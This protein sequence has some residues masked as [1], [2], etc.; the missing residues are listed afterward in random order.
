MKKNI[1]FITI[2]QAGGNIGLLFQELG[3]KVLFM[4]TS[5]EDL[6][7]LKGAKQ[8]YHI[9]NGE[10]CNK[11]RDKAKSLIFEDFSAISK[12]ILQNFKEEEFIYVIFSSGGGTGSGSSPMLIELLIQHLDKKVGAIT[13]LPN[14]N[15]PSKPFINAY[16]CFTELEGIENV[17][18]TFILDNNSNHDKL[19]INI[20]FVD[21]F[22][23]FINISGH[24]D[25]SGNI[26]TAEMKELLSTR[27][28]AIISKIAKSTSSTSSLLESVNKNIFAPLEGDKVIKY[29]G[30]STSAQIDTGDVMQE[31]GT[32][33]DVYQATNPDDT[34]AIFCGLSFPYAVLEQFRESIESSREAIT[35]S[36]TTTAEIKL[37]GGVN[38]LTNVRSNGVTPPKE[39]TEINDVFAKFMKK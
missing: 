32:C 35:K 31:V 20:E 38:F 15:E 28:A 2:G 3:Y 16:E 25:T 21:L 4:N 1:G 18:A 17:C 22:D 26:D 37:S 6:D 34:V 27:G 23:S 36:L 7:T 11:D 14:R 8:T 33:L 9:K 12:Q 39:K 24:Y 30:I 10:G 13:I 19:L 5:Q 29:I